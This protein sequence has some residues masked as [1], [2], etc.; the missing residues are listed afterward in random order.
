MLWKREPA[1]RRI[2]RVPTA[3]RGVAMLLDAAARIV[4]AH[5]L[6]VDLVPRLG[7]SLRPVTLVLLQLV[8]GVCYE[9]AGLWRL[10][11]SGS[12]A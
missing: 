12:A 4:M 6:P 8:N 9:L 5:T 10:T 7:A 3:I 11:R 2:W 1:F